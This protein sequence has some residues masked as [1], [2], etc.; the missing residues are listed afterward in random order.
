MF[1]IIAITILAVAALFVAWPLLGRGSNWRAIGLAVVVALPLGGALLYRDVGTPAALDASVH[2]MESTDFDSVADNLRSRLT[3][4]EEDLEGWLLLT[5]SLKSLQRYDEALEAAQTAHRIAPDN[6]V[7]K[8]ELAEAML[9]ASGNPRITDEIREMLQSAVEADPGL[10]KGL[11]LLGIDATQRGDDQQAIEFWQR[12]L[13]Q[14]E[15][16]SPVAGTVQEQI[17]IARDR[18]GL[19]PETPTAEAGAWPGISVEIAI[20]EFAAHVMP[21]PLPDSA[22]LF[23]IARPAG[24]TAGPPLG[25][26][27]LAQPRFPIRLTMDDSNA[28][29]PQRKL[30]QQEN[31]RFQARLSLSGQVTPGPGDW[32]SDALEVPTEDTESVNLTLAPAGE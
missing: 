15:P 11:W 19:E 28:M 5:R 3:E 23:V 20:D 17:N 13:A 10:Q 32:Q 21:D 14:V 7:V 16:G 6:P 8:A 2:E 30:S 26:A 1:W 12:L 18:L 25:V 22:V 24:E 27:R 4:S 29:M 31:L 9:Y